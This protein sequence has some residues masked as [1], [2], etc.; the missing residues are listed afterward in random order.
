VHL[1]PPPAW[2]LARRRIIGS[3]LRTARKHAGL[4]QIK[5]GELINRD[6]KS[7][8][9]WEN[10]HRALDIDDLIVI[11]DALDVPLADLVQ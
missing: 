4:T 6:A 3:H 10:G 5:L 7:I 9:R 11:A 8:S 2:V 1:D